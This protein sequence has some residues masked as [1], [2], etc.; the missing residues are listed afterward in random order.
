MHRHERVGP[1]I[2]KMH[3]LE[4]SGMSRS[5]SRLRQDIARKARAWDSDA[6]KEL[7]KKEGIDVIWPT[8]GR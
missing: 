3:L 1:L 2:Q 4:A 8:Y 6:M 5:A 7:M